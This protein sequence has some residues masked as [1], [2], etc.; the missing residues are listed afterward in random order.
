MNCRIG[1]SNLE[2]ISQIFYVTSPR[3][4]DVINFTLSLALLNLNAL[5]LQVSYF[6]L[7]WVTVLKGF[8][9]ITKSGNKRIYTHFFEEYL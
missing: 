4:F 6:Y 3:H 8:A 2:L 7:K 1:I 9:V 5:F